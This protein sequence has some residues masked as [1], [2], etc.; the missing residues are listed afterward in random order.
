SVE[1]DFN[2]AHDRHGLLAL[3]GRAH[4]AVENLRP[5]SLDAKGLGFRELSGDRGKLAMC[6]MS[7]FGRSGP[8]STWAS[9]GGAMAECANGMAMATGQDRPIVPG[10]ALGDIFT[11]LYAALGLC[12]QLY[13]QVHKGRG[14]YYEVTQFEAGASTLEELIALQP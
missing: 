6:S 14:S 5:G 9:Y 8:R 13:Q 2:S 7:G 10:R 3:A 12:A 11:G 1:F 4:A